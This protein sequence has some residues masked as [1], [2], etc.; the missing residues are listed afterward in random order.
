[1]ADVAAGARLEIAPGAAIGDGCRILVR[2]GT[3]RIGAGAVLGER[4]R[5]VAHAG[6]DLGERVVLGDDAV[7]LDFDHRFDD[8]ER[9]VRLQGLVSAPVRIATGARIGARAAVQRGVTVGESAEVGPLAVVTRD[10]P[11][12][13]RVGGVPA[14]SPSGPRPGTRGGS[15]SRPAR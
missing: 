11:P 4:C 12:G 10:V 14:L 13:A 15:R 8:V 5:L 1:V 3:V 2:G 9:P 7:V 6:I